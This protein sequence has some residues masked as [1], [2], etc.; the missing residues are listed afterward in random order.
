[1]RN[2]EGEDLEEAKEELIALLKLLEGELDE[3][4]YFSGE[5]FGF[6]DIALIPFS[7]WFHTYETMGNFSIEEE[8]P[9]LMDWVRR[10]MERDSVSKALPDPHRVYDLNCK[11]RE[12]L[13]FK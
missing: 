5:T 12:R 3:K 13:S 4:R 9:R 11:L 2:N 6:V 8:C 10:C 1:M 7:C